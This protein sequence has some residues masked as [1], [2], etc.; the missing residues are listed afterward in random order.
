V[1]L[2]P[3]G[4]AE[5]EISLIDALKSSPYAF[6]LPKP[7]GRTA[8]ETRP[9]DILHANHVE[10][11]DG[12]LEHL[13]PLFRRGNLLVSFRDI[14][15]IAILDGRTHR[16]L[17]L[18][19]PTNLAVQHHSTILPNGNVLV[20]NNRVRRS[21]VLEV[22]PRTNAVVWRY[23][24][25]D[26]DFF[27]SIRGSCQRLS[28]GDTLIGVSQAGYAV[29]VTPSGEVVWKFINPDINSDHF[30]Q[31]IYRIVRIEPG[32]LAFL[33]GSAGR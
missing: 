5:A 28:N 19:G 25:G 30:R 14:C 31:A 22:D 9:P 3:D 15:S 32:A 13:S 33:S 26:S 12:E 1:I 7:P 16:V 4:R 11:Y 20:F 21:E 27:S 18:W 29:E 10:V 6:L 8:S 24:P 17:W 2:S 23:D